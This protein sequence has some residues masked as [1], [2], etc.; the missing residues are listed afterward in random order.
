M[1]H[2]DLSSPTARLK[3]A[4]RREPYW[5]RIRSRGGRGLGYRRLLGSASGTWHV[6]WR[7]DGRANYRSMSFASADDMPAGQNIRGALAY[8]QAWDYAARFNPDVKDF[9]GSE[10]RTVNDAIKYYLGTYAPNRLKRPER[11]ATSC[12][13]H[14][15]P[16]LGNVAIRDISPA[17]IIR[18]MNAWASQPR[19]M[20]Y[21]NTRAVKTRDQQRS[22]RSSTNLLYKHLRMILNRAHKDGLVA[23]GISPRQW[24][25]DELPRAKRAGRPGRKK[26][27]LKREILAII[28]AAEMNDDF[29]NVFRAGLYTGARAHALISLTVG[30]YKRETKP[31]PTISF[32]ADDDKID[33]GRQTDLNADGVEFF[34][35]LTAGRA[36]D[37]PLL[38]RKKQ[39]RSG[40]ILDEHGEPTWQPWTGGNIRYW[41][42]KCSRAAGIPEGGITFHNAV[43]HTIATQARDAGVSREYL[44][45]QV[46]WKSTKMID[47]IYGGVT[48]ETRQ[49]QIEKWPT[50]DKPEHGDNVTDI[51]SGRKRKKGSA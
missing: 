38:R 28:R 34:D 50:L 39:N 35:G 48:S 24:T 20:P 10:V 14:I 51:A 37:E 18:Q 27:L 13:V 44:K 36:D 5:Q 43:R 33:Q 7:E 8:D 3:L 23:E 17:L 19:I 12:S 42:E 22:A 1:K 4:G 15:S 29:M 47:E 16:D 9:D 26:S 32:G 46:G 45:A 41:M 6:R 21:G 30:D 2:Y 11:V 49:A 31:R 25:V 40:V